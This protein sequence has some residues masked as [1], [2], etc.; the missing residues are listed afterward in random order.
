[1]KSNTMQGL[2]SWA[3]ALTLLAPGLTVAAPA[4]AQATEYDYIVVGSGPGGGP[5]AVNLAKAGYSVF[6]IEA[7]D[8]STATGFGQYPPAITWDFFVNHY[9]EGDPRN[10]QYSH[11]TWKTPEGRYWVGQTG[12]PA[13]SKLLGV[14]YPR[15]ATLGG[16]SMINAMCTWLPSDSDWNYVYEL[17][18]DATW[19][20]DNMRSIFTKIEH[21]NYMAKGT[22]GHGFDGFFQT[23]M[24]SKLQ[25]QRAPLK[26]NKV[27]TAY[28]SDL[29]LTMPMADLLQRDPNVLAADRDTTSSVYGLVQHQYSNGG[30]YSSRDYIQAAAQNTSI[31][32]TVSLNSLAT[33]VLFDSTASSKCGSSAA[34]VP[35]A[36]GVEYLEGKSLYAADSRRAAGATG[37]KKTVTA[38]REVIVSGGTF[39]S[40][41]LLMLSGVGPADH[42]AQFN[43]SVVKDLP[44]V[45]QNMMDN[46]E[47]PIV[48]SG[49]A[50][51]GDAGVAMIRTS[52]AA[53]G[54]E[55]DMFLM[56]GQ[57]FLFRGFWPDNQTARLPAD[58]PQPYGVSMVKGSSVNNK[59]WVRLRSA[60]AQDTPEINFNHYASGAEY[61]LAAMKDVIGWVRRIYL[62]IGITPREPPCSGTLD[63]SGGCGQEDDDWLHKQT[64]GHHPTSTNRIGADNDTMA[65]L[66]SK[67]RVRGVTGLRV[68]D[69]SAFARIPGV[70]PVVSTFMISQKASDDIIAELQAGTAIEQ[71]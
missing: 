31:P 4:A 53:Y 8:A 14:Y 3:V 60:N 7:G 32:L 70:F 13:G 59:G 18:G 54:A 10:N 51:T 57:G 17:T 48:G 62:A 25:A 41:Q 68:V 58:P 6:L 26:G 12:A 5:L 40:P 20:A 67:F 69:A 61:D 66:D 50:G 22:E 28:A 55:R 52:H 36:T 24:A 64:F 9:P 46:Q 16:S 56:G 1:M 47:M 33:R 43:I 11:L 27:V 38:K 65:V 21:N 45:G 19:K 71:C 30:R 2:I 42:L 34:A 44:G 37:V 35:R 15:G 63:A 39:N 23:N 29:N 49:S